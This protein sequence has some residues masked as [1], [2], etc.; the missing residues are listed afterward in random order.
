MGGDVICLAVELPSVSVPQGLDLEPERDS[1]PSD[2]APGVRQLPWR[3]GRT[4]LNLP[5]VCLTKASTEAIRDRVLLLPGRA[6]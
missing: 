2:V 5:S 3:G 6:T 4:A 1:Q